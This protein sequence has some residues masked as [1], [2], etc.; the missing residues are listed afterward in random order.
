MWSQSAQVY[1]Q[2]GNTCKI[3]QKDVKLHA[4]QVMQNQHQDFVLLNASQILKLL[5]MKLIKSVF[6]NANL[7]AYMLIIQLTNV[8]NLMAVMQL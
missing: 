5:P 2:K 7:L 8:F 6:M 4:I 3:Q 1:V